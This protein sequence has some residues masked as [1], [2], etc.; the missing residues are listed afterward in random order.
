MKNEK[1]ESVKI[2]DK[3]KVKY[4]AVCIVHWPS[5]PIYCCNLHAHALIHLSRFMGG[6]TV[7]TKLT[8]AD[9]KPQCSNCINENR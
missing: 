7:K 9:G 1:K 4:P 2:K 8:K 6:H 3:I 5:G